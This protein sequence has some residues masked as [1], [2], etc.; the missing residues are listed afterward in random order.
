MFQKGKMNMRSLRQLALASTLVLSF[1]FSIAAAPA[2][3]QAK[4]VFAFIQ[5]GSESGWRTAFTDSMKAE[6]V[7]EGIDLKFTDG[8]QKQE[9]QIAGLRAAIAQ[10]VDAIILAPIVETGWDAVLKE[11]KDAKIPVVLVDRNV[12]VSDDTLYYT[13]VAADFN[14]EGRLAASWLAAASAGTQWAS[15]CNIVELQG[16]TGSSAALD[17]AAGFADVLKL[18]PTMK[19]VASQNGDFTRDGGQKAMEALIKSQNNLKDVCAIWAHN[20][21]M[22]LG[23]LVA[24]KAAGIKTGPDGILTVSV[25]GVCDMFKAMS[26]GLTTANVTLLPDLGPLAYQAAKDAIA[27]KPAASK[28]TVMPSPMNF[29]PTAAAKYAACSSAA[30]PA[31]AATTAS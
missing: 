26:D 24:L 23:A 20:D 2:G 31:A 9:V 28:W 19:I 8:Q 3:A 10:K 21:D 11:A 17:R 13:R 4:P 1:A 27:G 25:D 7:K 12:K 5:T 16:T 29:P 22:L 15:G 30:A 6:A 14:H 18:F